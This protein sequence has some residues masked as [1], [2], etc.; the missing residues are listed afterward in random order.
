MVSPFPVRSWVPPRESSLG[1][2]GGAGDGSGNGAHP[3]WAGM[4]T[5]RGHPWGH[6]EM[7]LGGWP[8]RPQYGK[9]V[10]LGE[11]APG[12]AL[13]L[14]ARGCPRVWGTHEGCPES[15]ACLWG[16][17]TLLIPVIKGVKMTPCEQRWFIQAVGTSCPQRGS[18]L[19]TF[20]EG[21]EPPGAVR[22]P[23]GLA[24]GQLCPRPGHV[25]PKAQLPSGAGGKPASS[26]SSSSSSSVPQSHRW[27][28][29]GVG[30][31]HGDGGMGGSW[32][33]WGEEEEEEKEERRRRKKKRRSGRK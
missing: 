10:I 9:L 26:S 31:L 21:A 17:P 19:V 29:G 20:W 27:E 5:G 15:E 16:S 2:W 1:F 13:L 11:R 32:E 33:R 12:W 6:S 23:T 28:P 4:G 8:V 14:Q 24:Q 25:L 3:N 30:W 18:G 7:A 22:V